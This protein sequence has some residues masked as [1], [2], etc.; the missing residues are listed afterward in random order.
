MADR[1]ENDAYYTPDD[2]AA[3]C[4]ATI[5]HRI[6][7]AH[8]IEP[9]VGGGAFLHAAFNAGAVWPNTTACDIDPNAAGLAIAGCSHVVDFLTMPRPC[10]AGQIWVIGNPPYS[11][12]LEHVEHALSLALP[13]GGPAGGVAFLLRLQFLACLRRADLWRRHPV[14]ELHV[15]QRRPCFIGKTSEK[16]C[17]YGFFVWHAGE[18]QPVGWI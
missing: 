2:V 15:L 5:A 9:S 4:V 12:A 11:H 17:E 6:G 13:D 8:I 7:W 3:K 18:R 10:N 1:R 14:T 16:G